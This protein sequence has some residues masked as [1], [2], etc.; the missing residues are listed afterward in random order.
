MR[1]VLKEMFFV[2]KIAFYCK[3]QVIYLSM[4]DSVQ[5][6]FILRG[7]RLESRYA[8]IRCFVS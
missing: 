2:D 8:L 7:V 5:I 4:I 1:D 3:D 6:C